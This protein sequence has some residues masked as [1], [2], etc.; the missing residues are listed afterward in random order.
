MWE[1]LMWIVVGGAAGYIAE[2]L[3]GEDHNLVVNV[4]LGVAGAFLINILLATILGL[5][6]GNVIA[7]LLSGIAGACA[8]I[9][10]HREYKKRQ[11]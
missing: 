6:G 7:Q 8:L 2:R 1:F 4:A 10:I 5:T 9:W 3:M 11:P